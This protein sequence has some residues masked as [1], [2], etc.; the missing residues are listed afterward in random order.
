MSE[1]SVPQPQHVILSCPNSSS[2][3]TSEL[4]GR[5]SEALGRLRV[6]GSAGLLGRAVVDGASLLVPGHGE[7]VRATPFTM[8]GPYKEYSVHLH[9]DALS[10]PW[11]FRLQ[12]GK[13]FKAPLTIQRVSEITLFNIDCSVESIA[14]MAVT[15]RRGF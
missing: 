6:G 9:R 15:L 5:S 10:T 7:R 11:G 2:R 3:V 13:D 12:G 4:L 8:A 14:T 1:S